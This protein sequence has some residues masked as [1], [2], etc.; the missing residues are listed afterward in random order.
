MG[1]HQLVQSRAC[2]CALPHPSVTWPGS[3]CCSDPVFVQKSGKGPTVKKRPYTTVL[4]PSSGTL[5][6]STQQYTAAHGNSVCKKLTLTLSLT[7]W[8]NSL[9]SSLGN[10]QLSWADESRASSQVKSC[11][12]LPHHLRNIRQ[13][14]EVD[15]LLCPLHPHP[16]SPQWG[17]NLVH[18]LLTDQ[19]WPN[20]SPFKTALGNRHLWSDLAVLM[21]LSLFLKTSLLLLFFF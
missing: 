14:H 18:M 15:F 11:C 8:K 21:F 7:F 4:P 13:Q 6:A 3:S 10:S 2:L 12:H 19:T 20:S 1:K 9:P 17:H 16:R 5:P